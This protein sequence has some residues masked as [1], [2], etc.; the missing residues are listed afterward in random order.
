M[1]ASEPEIAL[2]RYGALTMS[3]DERV[4]IL[5]DIILEAINSEQ[6]LGTEAE[7]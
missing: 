2:G 1:N 7:G 6:A 5:A 4:A 3:D